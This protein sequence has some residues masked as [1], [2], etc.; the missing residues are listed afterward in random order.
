MSETKVYYLISH[1]YYSDEIDDV[2]NKVDIFS[3]IE[4]NEEATELDI[5]DVENVF[6][7]TQE[8]SGF[9]IYRIHKIMKT[10]GRF[11]VGDI[12]Y[13]EGGMIE[14][15]TKK[16]NGE[17]DQI[18]CYPTRVFEKEKIILCTSETIEIHLKY[19]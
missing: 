5:N 14:F 10:Q 2:I 6:E 15:C 7:I 12:I 11:A 19:I 3:E 16:P 17:I 18:C 13:F 8:E 9:K 4:N 1:D